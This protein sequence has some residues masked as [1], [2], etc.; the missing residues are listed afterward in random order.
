MGW[1]REEESFKGKAITK[2]SLL[3]TYSHQAV[4]EGQWQQYYEERVA[5]ELD[6][7]GANSDKSD[8][9]SSQPDPRSQ[10]ILESTR[11]RV[12]DS[13]HEAGFSEAQYGK[14]LAQLVYLLPFSGTSDGGDPKTITMATVFYS[15]YATVN[16]VSLV[17]EYHHNNDVTM[18]RCEQSD[19][20]TIPLVEVHKSETETRIKRLASRETLTRIKYFLFGDH[21][22]QL[23]PWRMF[24]LLFGAAAIDELGEDLIWITKNSAREYIIHNEDLYDNGF[25]G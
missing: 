7:Y 3:P 1:T 23:T 19:S 18:L 22:P 4:S 8:A 16:S 14:S 21:A 5:I 12:G 17:Y 13:L 20:A 10:E 15:P 9:E 24:E 25:F 11:A 2:W 6:G